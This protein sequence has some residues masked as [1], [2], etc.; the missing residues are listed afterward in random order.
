VAFELRCEDCEALFDSDTAGPAVYECS[1]CGQ[2]F[3]RDGSADG[4]SS[5]CP[6]CNIFAAAAADLSCPECESASIEHGEFSPPPPPT[7]AER[8][9]DAALKRRSDAHKA[10]L[11]AEHTARRDAQ[12]ERWT[13][14][15]GLGGAFGG[16]GRLDERAAQVLGDGSSILD[17]RLDEAEAI[18]AT[19][20][21]PTSPPAPA[22]QPGGDRGAH[23]AVRAA[24]RER[25]T[26][27]D[28]LARAFDGIPTPTGDFGEV[29][30]EAFGQMGAVGI[31][32]D[33]E[34]WQALARR[35]LDHRG[36]T[37]QPGAADGPA[38]HATTAQ[39]ALARAAEQTR[40]TA[41]PEERD[42]G[43]SRLPSG[44]WSSS[45]KLNAASAPQ[46]TPIA[47]ANVRNPT[48]R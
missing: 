8:A 23:A 48:T 7:P 43:D 33:E 34:P 6:N 37:K 29:A 19:G 3:T 12:R 40:P 44:Q 11:L 20:C 24:Q 36:V 5:R 22:A 38:I 21:W 30:E 35:L 27:P 16:I 4:D 28:G 26:G 25:W 15:N 32:V 47:T 42:P 18:A 31:G 2:E 14:P 10:A 17:L 46:Q 45:T 13:G 41:P 9:A 39:Q 1:R